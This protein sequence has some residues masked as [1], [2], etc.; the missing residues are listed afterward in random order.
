M[1]KILDEKFKIRISLF[2]R[3]TLELDAIDYNFVKTD[4]KPNLNSFLNKL[5][6]NLLK[7]KKIRRKRIFSSVANVFG[8]PNND[9][10]G[11]EKLIYELNAIYDEVYFSDAELNEL[12]EVV[13]IRPT[14]DNIA[15][16]DEIQDSETQITGL[17]MS[18]YLR[19][20][21][22]E[23]ARFPKYKK[24]QIVFLDECAITL[25]ARNH[26][27]ILKF[28][29]EGDL[30]RAYVFGCVYDYLNEQGNYILCLDLTLNII[31]RYQV[32]EMEALHIL[33]RK[34]RPSSK[35][36]GLCQKYVNEALW[37]DDYVLEIGEEDEE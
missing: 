26:A 3:Q 30:R 10:A 11:A 36:T 25:R 2:L 23:F 22:N 13:W 29:Y 33:D 37:I 4:G 5:I 19:T 35:I 31:C 1:I 18:S 14:K 28:R 27:N 32:C 12:S 34:Y 21:L 9:M 16:F 24:E 20:L 17:D 15:I 6:P 7:L 8:I